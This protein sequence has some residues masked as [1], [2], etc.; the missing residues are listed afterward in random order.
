MFFE[1]QPVN[2]NE[3]KN[4]IQPIGS[5]THQAAPINNDADALLSS[6]YFKPIHPVQPLKRNNFKK[7]NKLLIFIL[8]IKPNL[9]IF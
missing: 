9:M 5:K 3:L 1:P 7:I 2:K 4:S 8:F 6:R